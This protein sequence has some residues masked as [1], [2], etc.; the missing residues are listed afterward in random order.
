[1]RFYRDGRDKGSFDTGIEM[2]LRRILASPEFIFR[3]EQDPEEASSG[4]AYPVSDLELASRLSF[5]LWSSLPD[6]EL[7]E[8]ATQGRLR[9]PA[10]MEAQVRRMLADARSVAL[11]ENFAG[12]WLYLRNL[13]NIDP[14]YGQFADFDANLKRAFRKQTELFFESII[15]E[16]RSVL[17]LLSASDTFLN[18]RLAT[19][20]GIPGVYGSHFR[21]VELGDEFDYRRGLLGQGSI[22]TVTSYPNRTSPVQRGKWILENLLGVPAPTP[23]PNVPELQETAAP[24]IELTSVRARME[25]HRTNPV[26]AACHKIMDPIGFAMENF[27]AVGRW[28][29]QDEGSPIDASGELVDGTPIDGPSGLRAAL[30][31]YSHQFVQNMTERLLTYAMGRGLE[32]YDMPVVRAIAREAAA[33]DYRFSSLVLGVVQSA[34]FQMKTLEASRPDATGP[35]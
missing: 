14:D 23:P 33:D 25:A 9:R 6:A 1:M 21:R 8:A 18:E 27:D 11:V 35:E 13:E 26:C 30:E 10:Q 19:H 22:L 34:G 17:D 32:Y 3:F 15:R 5:F 2:A 29:D 24:G 4:V 16:D 20:Y 7:L 28:R 12:Q 31:G